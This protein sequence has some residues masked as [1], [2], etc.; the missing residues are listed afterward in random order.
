MPLARLVKFIVLF[1]RSAG[2]YIKH[3]TRY[4]LFILAAG[5]MRNSL[6]KLLVFTDIYALSRDCLN[7][8]ISSSEY[9]SHGWSDG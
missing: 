2:H 8:T 6:E 7:S 4:A 3:D 5:K 1:E 9:S